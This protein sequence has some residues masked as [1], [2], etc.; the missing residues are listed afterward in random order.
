M[1]K[2]ELVVS[3]TALKEVRD[4]IQKKIDL[5]ESELKNF[6]DKSEN[7]THDEKTESGYYSYLTMIKKLN[8]HTANNYLSNLRGIK[9]RL[10]K[11]SN[12]EIIGEIYNISD[13]DI[14]LNIKHQMEKSEKF[15]KDNKTIHNGYT[16]AFNNYVTYIFNFYKKDEETLPSKFVFDD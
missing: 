10:K 1:N 16:A 9:K 11:Y 5:L 7:S 6:E 8:D 3:I 15:Q 12:F 4:D 14:L 13:K 2:E